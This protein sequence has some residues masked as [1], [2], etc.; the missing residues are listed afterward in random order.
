MLIYATETPRLFPG[1]QV[2]LIDPL[3][4]GEITVVT[5]WITLAEVLVKPLSLADVILEIDV[6]AVPYTLRTPWIL[7]VDRH[8]AEQAAR[9]RHTFGLKLPDAIH[10]GTG[11]AAGAHIFYPATASGIELA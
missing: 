4:R 1:L 3:A 10:I 7:G 8:T 11:M 6:S 2:R 5:S 9:L